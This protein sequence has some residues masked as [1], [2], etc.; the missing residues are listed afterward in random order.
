MLRLAFDFIITWRETRT[1]PNAYETDRNL[2]EEEFLSSVSFR[3]LIAEGEVPEVRL[4]FRNV[5]HVLSHR[6]IYANFYEVVLPEN[7]RSF[8]EYQCIRM[9]DL[10]QYPVSRLVHAFL[11]K[12]L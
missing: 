11:E 1:R 3:S 4:V 6:V 5:K 7:S 9:E 12:Y 10:E 8:S 2:S